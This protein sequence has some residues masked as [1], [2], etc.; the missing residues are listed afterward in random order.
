M[1]PWRRRILDV[2]SRVRWL[3]PLVARVALGLTFLRTG[4]IALHNLS[5]VAA[6]FAKLEIPAPGMQAPFV[7]AVE[8]VCGALLLA[9]FLTRLASLPLL[10]TMVVAIATAKKGEVHALRDLFGM[11]KFLYVAL[12]LWLGAF[13]GG[14]VSVDAALAK[15]LD[16]GRR[17][18]IST[19]A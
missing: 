9:G 1:R 6:Y 4:W 7:A 13:G 15:L 18:P 14:T 12:L 11:A 5:G 19:L 3:P 2:S 10:G 16:D 17:A 8:F